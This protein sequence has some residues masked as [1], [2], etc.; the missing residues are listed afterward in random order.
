MKRLRWI[1]VLLVVVGILW[2]LST[3]NHPAPPGANRSFTDLE[4]ALASGGPRGWEL[5]AR[6]PHPGPY[7]L[8]PG[9]DMLGRTEGTGLTCRVYDDRGKVLEEVRLKAI[10]GCDQLVVYLEAPGGHRTMAVLRRPG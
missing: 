8:I 7:R 5:H 9:G 2:G 3:Q 1:G 4:T 10:P 6:P